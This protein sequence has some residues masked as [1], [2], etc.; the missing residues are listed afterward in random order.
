MLAPRKRFINV[1]SKYFGIF[2][3]FDRISSN[4][5]MLFLEKL[6]QSLTGSDEDIF[7]LRNTKGRA[8]LPVVII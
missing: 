3:S 5:Y 4:A 8:Y 6:S 1:N 2:E 7:C